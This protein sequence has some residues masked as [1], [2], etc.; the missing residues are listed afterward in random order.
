MSFATSPFGQLHLPAD[1]DRV[2]R[3]QQ[4]L[5]NDCLPFQCQY[6]ELVESSVR[7][8]EKLYI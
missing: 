5:F 6:E 7:H 3:A 4:K 1:T 2:V 8:A